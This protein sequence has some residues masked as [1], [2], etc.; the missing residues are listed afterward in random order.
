MDSNIPPAGWSGKKENRKKMSV[1]LPFCGRFL[2]TSGIQ[3][4]FL[5][6]S[7]SNYNPKQGHHFWHF[8]AFVLLNFYLPHPTPPP[9]TAQPLGWQRGRFTVRMRRLDS[10]WFAFRGARWCNYRQLDTSGGEFKG[11]CPSLTPPLSLDR[12]VHSSV[13]SHWFQRFTTWGRR[14]KQN[15]SAERRSARRRRKGEEWR[16]KSKSEKS[17]TF[18][19]DFYFTLDKMINSALCHTSNVFFFLSSWDHACLKKNFLLDRCE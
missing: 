11:G 15:K 5:R 8:L 2:S 4:N 19:R 17:I 9:R 16:E 18:W 1:F 7:S 6:Y 12:N 14:A 3:G 13:L 10:I